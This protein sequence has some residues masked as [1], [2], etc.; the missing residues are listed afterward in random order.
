MRLA[1]V[2][3]FLWLSACQIHTA[4]PGAAT[5]P[6]IGRSA[7]ATDLAAVESGVLAGINSERR[8]RGLPPFQHDAALAAIARAHSQDMASRGYFQHVAPDG[9]RPH[10]R[11]SRAGYTFRRFGEN[12]FQGVLYASFTYTDRSDPRTHLYDWRSEEEMA[13]LTVRSWLDSP[14]HRELMLSRDFTRAGVGIAPGAEHRYLV[15]L[16]VSFP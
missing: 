8:T 11:A 5:T 13:D 2:P 3:L 15:T 10:T 4:G 14:P 9:S 7:P 1:L 16:N 12:I 6:A